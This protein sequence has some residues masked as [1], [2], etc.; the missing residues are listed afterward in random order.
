MYIAPQ[1]I[2]VV[3]KP[4]EGEETRHDLRE[5]ANQAAPSP[6][7]DQHHVRYAVQMG[8]PHHHSVHKRSE[9]I[10]DEVKSC[11]VAE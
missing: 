8:G 4:G 6:C 2:N 3:I 7:Q 11:Q 5:A 1:K 10:S 9:E